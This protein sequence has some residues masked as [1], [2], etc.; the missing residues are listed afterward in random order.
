MT[1]AN[2]AV[3]PALHALLNPPPPCTYNIAHHTSSSMVFCAA[4]ADTLPSLALRECERP[5]CSEIV[6]GT[7]SSPCNSKSP[8]L[9]FLWDARA[10]SMAC[11]SAVS[12]RQPP[13]GRG[14]RN[15]GGEGKQAVRKSTPPQHGRVRAAEF[16]VRTD[17]LDP[18]GKTR[19]Q[20]TAPPADACARRARHLS[21]RQGKGY[22]GF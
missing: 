10:M 2:Q 20:Q 3:I 15:R 8:R 16:D 22:Y 13:R 17:M 12:G 14:C 18:A 7:R 19:L 6:G 9:R 11:Q 5:T 21:A 1:C 4:I